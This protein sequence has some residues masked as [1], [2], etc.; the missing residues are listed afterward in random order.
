MAKTPVMDELSHK[1]PGTLLNASGEAVGLPFDEPGNSEV[2]HQNIGSGQLVEQDLSSINKMIDSGEFF[3]NNVLNQIFEKT[4]KDKCK[5]HLIG[6][7]SDGGIHSNIKHLF[8]LLELAQKKKLKNVIIHIITDGRDSPTTSGLKYL[9]QLENKMAECKVGKIATISGRYY[10]MDRDNHWDRVKEYFWVITGQTPEIKASVEKIL[11]SSYAEGITDEFIKPVLIDKNASISSGDSI[12]FFNFRSDRMRQIVKSISL[13]KFKE[14]DRGKPPADL[15]IATFS[16]YQDNLPAQVVFSSDKIRVCLSS[17][18]AAN[19]ISHFHIA[20]TEKYA[21]VT[22]FFN[23]GIEQPFKGEKRLLIPSPAVKT[24]DLKPEMSAKKVTKKTIDFFK[25]NR[26]DV[27]IINFA[28]ADMVGHTGDFYAAMKAVQIVDTCLGQI[29]RFAEQKKAIV[30]V[31]AD[32]GNAEQMINPLTGLPDTE[33][34]NNPVPFFIL[35]QEKFT[36]KRQGKLSDISPTILK[37]LKVE[38]PKE[39]TGESL[40]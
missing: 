15:N 32:H 27:T 35:G 40:F 30:L 1:S 17:V 23:G 26:P 29:L 8:A 21:H 20:E 24:Y 6:L 33:H 18:M 19:N 36:L 39:M 37:L 31:T 2:G 4:A 11:K 34:T 13:K 3:H 14:F 9:K 38:Q 22:Y 7:M 10:A 28:N 5:L 16:S 25:K 12:I